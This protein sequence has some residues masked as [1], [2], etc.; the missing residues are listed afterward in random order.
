MKQQLVLVAGANGAGKSSLFGDLF[1]GH[2]RVDADEIGER[3]RT[4]AGSTKIVPAGRAAL[5]LLRSA[6]SDRRDIVFETTLSGATAFRAA[7]EARRR[8]YG[9]VCI[10]LVLS[11]ADQHVERVRMRVAGGGHHVP[12]DVIR[13][14][15]VRSRRNFSARAGEFDAVFVLDN[16]DIPRCIGQR[17]AFED[18]SAAS[19]GVT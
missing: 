6:M 16:S 11:S 9:V 17:L 8:G 19:F 4:P 3:D 1:P 15:F 18:D 5:G 14:R 2:V 7:R 10:Y 13:R 12:K